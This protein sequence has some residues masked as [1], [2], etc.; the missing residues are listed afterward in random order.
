MHPEFIEEQINK[1]METFL[2]NINRKSRYLNKS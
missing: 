1:T 2:K